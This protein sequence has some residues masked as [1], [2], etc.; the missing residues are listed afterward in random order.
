LRFRDPR[1]PGGCDLLIG[2]ALAPEL[3]FKGPGAGKDGVC[4]AIDKTRQGDQVQTHSIE[5]LISLAQVSYRQIL[6]RPYPSDT[7]GADQYGSVLDY[8]QFGHRTSDARSRTP[9]Q[10]Q[11]LG[12]VFYDQHTG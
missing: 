5:D 4:V 9:L 8:A 7:I 3:I 11:Y 6:G 2:L 10:G 1:Y 12:D